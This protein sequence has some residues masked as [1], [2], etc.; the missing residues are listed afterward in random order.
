M[1]KRE[2]LRPFEDLLRV[3][4]E[5]LKQLEVQ[6]L[7][8]AG[9]ALGEELRLG[10]AVHRW[11]WLLHAVLGR[12]GAGLATLG[13]GPQPLIVVFWPNGG[14]G[15]G[16]GRGG[17]RLWPLQHLSRGPLRGWLGAGTRMLI[18]TRRLA[19]GCLGPADGNSGR[20]CGSLGVAIGQELGW[21]PGDEWGEEGIQLGE[22]VAGHAAITGRTPK[23]SAWRR[24]VERG[25]GAHLLINLLDGALLFLEGL[26]GFRLLGEARLDL[27]DVI[28]GL[29]E[30]DRRLLG[31]GLRRGRLRLRLNLYRWLQGRDL[32]LLGLWQWRRLA[33]IGAWLRLDWRV[34][35]RHRRRHVLRWLR[36]HRLHWRPRARLTAGARAIALWLRAGD[37]LRPGGR[38]VLKPRMSSRWPWKSCSTRSMTPGVSMDCALNSF[39]MSRNCRAG[40]REAQRDEWLGRCREQR[41]AR[42]RDA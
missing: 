1:H 39:I 41:V 34:A 22:R 19:L 7:G 24:E 6:A 30:L 14:R 16:G 3:E 11:A 15:R 13:L 26:V 31:L 38:N 9:A 27:C 37:T 4:V 20:G 42:S 28:D 17:G 40:G 23:R 12:L 36:R 5:A 18:G 32:R 35:R 25:W 21:T 29:I 33:E 2:K 8:H 10:R